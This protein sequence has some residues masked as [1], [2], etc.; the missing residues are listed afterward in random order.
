MLDVAVIEDPAA[1][2]VS[3]DP[4]RARLLAELAEPASATMLAGRVG[5]AR[6]KVNYHLKALEQHG[7]IE[8]VEQRRKGNVTERV[9]RATAGSYVIS[10]AALPTV[11]PDPA[12]APDRLS[13]R[14]LLAVA[15]RLVRDVGSLI[16]GADRANKR[17]ATF[18]IDGEI[19]FGSA[20]DRA[21][22][23]EELTNAVT[24]LVGK[25]HDETTP[26]GRPH[27]LVVAL[28]PSTSTDSPQEG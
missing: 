21:A 12:R 19:R 20:A 11:A 10:P 8:L 5:L 23:A 16:T 25:Y 27:R 28:H 3:L 1:A 17:V 4:I 14:W 22:F 9:M 18:A 15:A 13:A 7:L 26:G 24:T 6:Q 2:E